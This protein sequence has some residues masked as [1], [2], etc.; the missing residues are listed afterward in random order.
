MGAEFEPYE[1]AMRKAIRSRVTRGHLDV[2]VS[3]SANGSGAALFNRTLLEAWIR[4]WRLAAAE[5]G[6]AGEPDLNAAF[7]TPGMLA[8]E[9]GA[10]LS[11]ETG[12]ALRLTLEE[13]LDALDEE[14][15]REGS[16]TA[17]VLA[18]HA[19]RIGEA[20]TAMESV[21]GEVAGF[22]LERLNQRLGELLASSLVEPARIAQEAALLAE[23]SD[24]SEELARLRIH[25]R[26]ILD[27]L[28]QGGEIGKKLDF[29]L[30]EMSREV[31]TL[32]AKSNA[33]GEKGRHLSALGLT[34]KSEIEKLREQSLNLE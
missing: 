5:Y 26:R 24:I 20:V 29:V 6:L 31:N 2:R 19:V 32:M 13:A 25:Q 27:M 16:A 10:E 4:T 11:A 15:Q 21:R 28:D 22:L 34:V 12:D 14:R 7:R 9:N 33:A 1:A 8:P 30:Q 17:A 23:R 3:L 18:A